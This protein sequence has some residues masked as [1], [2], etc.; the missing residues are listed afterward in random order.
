M[1]LNLLSLDNEADHPDPSKCE[2]P[3]GQHLRALLK[4][5]KQSWLGMLFVVQLLSRVSAT[6]W[7]AARQ[8]S[9]S[10]TIS[11]SLLMSVELVMPSNRLLL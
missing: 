6:P 5:K 7:T 1:P 3:E 4:P 11:W 2:C 9:L 10:L 8:A